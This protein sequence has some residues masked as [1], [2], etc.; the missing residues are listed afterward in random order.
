M[1]DQKKMTEIN[2]AVSSKTEQ[3]PW[4]KVVNLQR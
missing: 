4:E 1:R 3:T 2:L